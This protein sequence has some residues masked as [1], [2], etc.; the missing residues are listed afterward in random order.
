MRFL[1]TAVSGS[2]RSMCG[3]RVPSSTGVPLTGSR[4]Q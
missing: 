1:R 3:S 4:F 2:A